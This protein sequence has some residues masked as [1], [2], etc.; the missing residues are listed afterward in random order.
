MEKITPA[1]VPYNRNMHEIRNKNILFKLNTGIG[2]F[3]L[4]IHGFLFSWDMNSLCR[5]SKWKR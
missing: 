5:A 4:L 3:L 2:N 1:L